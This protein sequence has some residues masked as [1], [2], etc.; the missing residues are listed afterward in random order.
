MG[1]KVFEKVSGFLSQNRS[2]FSNTPHQTK[3]KGVLKMNNTLINQLAMEIQ[4]LESEV[5]RLQASNELFQEMYPWI[6]K[7]SRKLY[8]NMATYHGDLYEIQGRVEEG[9]L[10]WVR[11]L[12]AHEP[13]SVE[14]GNF[15]GFIR[16]HVRN[17]MKKYKSML[18]ADMRNISHEQFSLNDTASNDSDSTF[19]ELVGDYS[20]VSLQ[21][22]TT[23]SMDMESL[24]V[25]FSIT[26]KN[27]DMK[28]QVVEKMINS[29][30]FDNQDVAEALGFDSYT[31]SARQKARRIKKEFA[32][33]LSQKGY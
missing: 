23:F 20:V 12:D 29:Q 30:L 3:S 22:S 28:A 18:T 31:N 19:G 14:Q 25:E 1:S 7:Q 2:G 6:E 24:I 33:F 16:G 10:R 4:S 26:V 15:V 13:Y 21:E 32:Q 8:S 9:I 17:E 27:G 11:F 5:A